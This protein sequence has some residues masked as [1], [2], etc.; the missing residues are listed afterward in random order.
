MTVDEAAELLMRNK[1]EFVL[2]RTKTG[3]Q[4]REYTESAGGSSRLV[5]QAPTLVELVK[6]VLG[7]RKQ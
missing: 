1:F 4:Y 7:R 6:K 3:Y 2:R 5:A